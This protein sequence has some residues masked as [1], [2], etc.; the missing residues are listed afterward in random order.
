MIFWNQLAQQTLNK[1]FNKIKIDKKV[2]IPFIIIHW[3][4]HIWKSSLIIEKSKE[5]LW[6]YFIQ[7]FLHLQD[8]S[9]KIWKKHPIKIEKKKWELTD[10]L[11][12]E[13]WYNDIWIR[14]TNERLSQSSISWYKI[15]FLENIQRLTNSASNALLKTCEEP[16]P[17]RLIIA[18]VD[19]LWNILDT[20]VSRAFIIKMNTL[21]S[22]TLE[23]FVEYLQQNNII[24]NIP[25]EISE[26]INLS[27]GKPWILYKFLKNNDQIQTI[28]LLKKFT[29][30]K[31][32][33]E[34]FLII[35]NIENAGNLNLFFDYIITKNLDKWE[36]IKNLKIKLNNNVNKEWVFLYLA[37]IL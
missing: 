9:E 31:S 2:P 6:N 1:I 17:N 32:I 7:D 11:S 34:K 5:F 30:S 10:K 12:K 16:L 25:D 24:K 3:P 29:E 23:Q 4:N 26:L 37:S 22:N 21:D 8:F 20:L 36:K 33:S 18:T 27:M 35:K 28:N 15:V 14:E 13:Y 19:S